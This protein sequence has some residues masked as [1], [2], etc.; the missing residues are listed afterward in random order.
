MR[1]KEAVSIKEKNDLDELLWK[2]LWEPLGIPRDFRKTVS[3]S[4]PEI[5]LI[6][7]ED[8]TAIG[9][10]VAS[11][12]AANVL[13]IR[14]IAVQAGYR[15]NST[16]R[17]LVE[18]LTQQV[19]TN[20]FVNI[21]TYARNTSAGFFAELGFHHTGEHLEHEVFTAHGIIFQKMYCTIH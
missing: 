2:V 14:H 7:L 21:Q 3:L 11:S 5:E 17:H 15:R 6:A 1:I 8:G 10:I 4:S 20:G 12:V 19:K 16:G 18:E 13:E 9:G